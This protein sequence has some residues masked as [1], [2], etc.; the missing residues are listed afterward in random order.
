MKHILS[1]KGRAVGLTRAYDFQVMHLDTLGRV[2]LWY[3]MPGEKWEIGHGRDIPTD[4]SANDV[5]ETMR[6]YLLD[7]ISQDD[8]NAILP[9]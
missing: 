1:F 9:R 8:Y 6:Q 3:R 4:M 5:A 7:N 2:Q